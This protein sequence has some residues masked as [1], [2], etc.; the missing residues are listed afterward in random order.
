MYTITHSVQ[1][2]HNK[3]NLRP[4]NVRTKLLC[5]SAQSYPSKENII[6][7]MLAQHLSHH[8]TIQTTIQTNGR[9]NASSSLRPLG[10]RCRGRHGAAV[11]KASGRGTPVRRLRVENVITPT[12]N[13]KATT[14][15][16]CLGLAAAALFHAPAAFAAAAENAVPSAFAA[17][18]HY[19]G[20]LLIVGSLAT[21]KAILKP[22][23]SGDE[24]MKL[25]IADSVYGIAGVLVLYTG[26][27]R[28][29][30]YGKGWEFYSHEPI[31]WFK[32][33]LF[34]VMGSSSLF[35]TIKTI[36]TF[37]EKQKSTDENETYISEKLATRMGKVLN[38]E[39]LAVLAIPLAATTMS[40][41]ILF[42]Q[43]MDWHLGAAPVAL[44]SA[45]L[46]FKYVKEALT[47][48]ED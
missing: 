46:G 6:T 47:W 3:M 27:L 28:V 23:M 45:G 14:T 30:Q 4:K 20:L 33:F 31:F 21:E 48:S 12:T 2:K 36:T 42:Q 5:L 16:G 35:V 15:T 38:G 43:E 10:L 34:A 32:M 39:L 37:A 24:L 22:N 1:K 44:A 17:Y 11:L 41:G 18:G 9:T 7:P 40:R 13:K 8:A 26:Y 29:T 19:L 25:V